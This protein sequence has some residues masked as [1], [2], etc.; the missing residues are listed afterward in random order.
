LIVDE[1][2]WYKSALSLYDVA[3]ETDSLIKYANKGHVELTDDQKELA[4]YISKKLT[5]KN[6]ILE[7]VKVTMSELKKKVANPI[8][9][10]IMGDKQKG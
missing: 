7:T 2:N 6:K 10:K 3:I 5:K 1:N 8:I 9:Q 4:D